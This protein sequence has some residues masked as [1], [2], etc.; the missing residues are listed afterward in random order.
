MDNINPTH[1]RNRRA[2]FYL[3]VL[4]FPLLIVG[5]IAVVLVV[6]MTQFPAFG[7]NTI[8]AMIFL[9]GVAL[10]GVVGGG[11]GVFRGLTL[12]RENEVALQVGD[13][14]RQS[15]DERFVFIRNVSRRRLGYIDAVLVGPPGVLIMRIVDHQGTWRNERAEWKIK[16]GNGTMGAAPS[17]PSR[18]CAK[19]VYAM[20]RYLNQK[21]LLDIPVYGLVV[22]HSR[23]LILQGESPVVPITETNRMVEVMQRDYL[24]EEPRI[25]PQQA[26]DTINAIING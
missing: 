1:N 13:F 11:I 12:D 19:D 15:L 16:R 9:G 5:I 26:Q 17:N 22:F 3:G 18:E 24:T 23:N 20:R 10:V 7:D 8:F 14:L 4:G 21:N 6:L 25:S 2:L